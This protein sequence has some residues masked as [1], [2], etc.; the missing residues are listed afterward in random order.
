MHDTY[1]LYI[2]I[3]HMESISG[4]HVRAAYMNDNIDSASGQMYEPHGSELVLHVSVYITNRSLVVCV[5]VCV[6]SS[7]R[8]TAYYI[9]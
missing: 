3:V 8:E 1:A 4:Q 7:V 6:Y 9:M 2:W 5:C